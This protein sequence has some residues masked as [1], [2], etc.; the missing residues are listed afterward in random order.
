MLLT[1]NGCNDCGS[2][3]T[4]EIKI[5][6]TGFPYW[7]CPECG[8]LHEDHSWYRVV[9][10]EK[11][12]NIIRFGGDERICFVCITGCEVVCVD[13]RKGKNEYEEFADLK[14]CLIWLVRGDVLK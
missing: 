7:M 8:V 3:G 12:R 5:D 6:N 14:E 11:M 10:I 4:H 1:T 9:D 2:Y 13:N